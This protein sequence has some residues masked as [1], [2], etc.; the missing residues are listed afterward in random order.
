MSH[1]FFQPFFQRKL[2]VLSKVSPLEENVFLDYKT[3]LLKPLEEGF[4]TE[5]L[6]C[7]S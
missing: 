7:R 4:N 2:S 5:A 3:S 6:I 1:R